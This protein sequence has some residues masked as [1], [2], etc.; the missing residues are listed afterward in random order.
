MSNLAVEA[1]FAALDP[2]ITR[3]LIEEP[4]SNHIRRAIRRPPNV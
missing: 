3:F 4:G 1:A 2:W